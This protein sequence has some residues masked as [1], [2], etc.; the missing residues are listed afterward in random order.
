MVVECRADIFYSFVMRVDRGL[1]RRE[2]GDFSLY[3][4]D[5]GV[6]SVD[7]F[8]NLCLMRGNILRNLRVVFRET[9]RH[10]GRYNR[11]KLREHVIH[12]ARIVNIE[13]LWCLCCI[14]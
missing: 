2:A 6:L 13:M 11:L 9:N 12:Y 5:R 3:V 14:G 7:S 10:F 4:I 1:Q 8:E